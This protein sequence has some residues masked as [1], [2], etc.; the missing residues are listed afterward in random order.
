MTLNPQLGFGVHCFQLL[1]A[2]TGDSNLATSGDFSWPR[3]TRV[4]FTSRG[5]DYPTNN[6]ELSSVNRIRSLTRRRIAL[7]KRAR[8]RHDA[9]RSKWLASPTGGA[10]MTVATHQPNQPSSDPAV[11]SWVRSQRR[12]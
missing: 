12:A 2:K 4:H 11:G 9:F 5:S 3:T 8:S 7:A 10:G 6:L 1:P